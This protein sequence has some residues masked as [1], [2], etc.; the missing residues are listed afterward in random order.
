LIS[1]N[2]G[3]P[4]GQGSATVFTPTRQRSTTHQFGTGLC[5]P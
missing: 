4:S 3:T 2:T 1:T 5:P